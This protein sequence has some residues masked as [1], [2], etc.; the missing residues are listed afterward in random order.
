MS[1]MESPATPQ[2]EEALPARDRVANQLFRGLSTGF[3]WLVILAV[4]YIVGTIAYE[5][6]PAIRKDGLDFLSSRVWDRNQDLYGILPQIWG[7]LYTSI[8][9]LVVGGVFGL[10]VA[11]FLNEGFLAGFIFIVLKRFNLQFHRYWGK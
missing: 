6:I 2:V 3:A 10:A 5:S 1:V 8:L 9:A 7:T 4:F 11:V